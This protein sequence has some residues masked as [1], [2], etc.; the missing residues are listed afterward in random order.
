MAYSKEH[1]RALL[2]LVETVCARPENK[3]FKDALSQTVCGVGSVDEQQKAITDELRRT[4]AYLIRIDR[5]FKREA[6]W[7][8]NKVKNQ[9]IKNKLVQYYRQMKIAEIE[10]DFLEYSRNI[11]LQLEAAFNFIIQKVDAWEVINKQP[12]YYNEIRVGNFSFFTQENGSKIPKPISKIG[13]PTKLK[14]VELYYQFAPYT[15]DYNI[16]HTLIFI[17][18]KASHGQEVEG[19]DKQKL[20]EIERNAPLHK[21]DFYSLLEKVSAELKDLYT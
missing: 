3:W 5:N 1:L 13:F 15:Y 20:E 10:E 17:R 2:Q 16:S 12:G 9:G 8:Y 19:K 4:R 11:S 6:L 18:N 14:F 21:M 7:F